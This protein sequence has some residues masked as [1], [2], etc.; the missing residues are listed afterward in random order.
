MV[1]GSCSAS[2]PKDPGLWGKGEGEATSPGLSFPIL[3]MG[4]SPK[5]QEPLCPYAAPKELSHIHNQR[6]VYM[7]YVLI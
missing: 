5:N 7:R 3:Q 4:M 6:K 1:E 2:S